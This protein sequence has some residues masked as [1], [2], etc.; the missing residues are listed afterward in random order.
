MH[1]IQ[2]TRNSKLDSLME[3]KNSCDRFPL[4]ESALGVP[5]QVHRISP[6]VISLCWLA[7]LA[8]LVAAAL[9]VSLLSK[10]LG[11]TVPLR[12]AMLLGAA[13]LTEALVP[14]VMA[15]HFRT[16]AYLVFRDGLVHV[17]GS[18]RTIVRWDEITEVFEKRTY[19]GT[20]YRIVL[21][22]GRTTS[23]TPILTNHDELGATIAARVT[24]AVTPQVLRFFENGGTVSFPLAV[25]A[26][27]ATSRST[28]VAWGRITRLPLGATP[29]M[30]SVQTTGAVDDSRNTAGAH[31]R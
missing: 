14:I 7:A 4:D 26:D 22:D 6:R 17:R 2:L 23:I 8:C 18:R 20:R 13:L 12:H 25:S 9:V 30:T 31:S 11:T 3:T 24:E 19:R 1:S 21:S 16:V 28:Q 10:R 5:D 29:Q 15:V 27:P